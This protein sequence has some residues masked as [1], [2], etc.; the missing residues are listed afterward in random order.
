MHFVLLAMDKHMKFVRNC[1]LLLLLL[2]APLAASQAAGLYKW[3]D[4]EGNTHYSQLPPSGRTAQ[5][6]KP[7]KDAPAP[8]ATQQKEEDAIPEEAKSNADELKVKRQNCEIAKGNMQTYK[9]SQ[10]IRQADGKIIELSDEMREAKIKE[11]QK[12]IDNYCS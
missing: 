8:E 2:T 12:M 1:A 11:A 4:D 5:K 7:P 6:L 9:D 3:T 10:K